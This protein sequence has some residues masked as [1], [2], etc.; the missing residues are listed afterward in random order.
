MSISMLG[1][2]LCQQPKGPTLGRPA[3][4][5]VI[6]ASSSPGGSRQTLETQALPG[7]TDAANPLADDGLAG[8]SIKVSYKPLP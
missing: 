3:H 6:L 2:Q 7:V 8:P 1:R 5:P 4:M